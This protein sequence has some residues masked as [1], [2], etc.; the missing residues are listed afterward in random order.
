MGRGKGTGHIVSFHGCTSASLELVLPYR[1]H[2]LGIQLGSVSSMS[3]SFSSVMLGRWQANM[4]SS[5]D[6]SLSEDLLSSWY[7]S[8]QHTVLRE[9]GDGHALGVSGPKDKF[10]CVKT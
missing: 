4:S 9:L 5:G 6:W 7:V 2:H 10:S 1:S 3:S 8:W